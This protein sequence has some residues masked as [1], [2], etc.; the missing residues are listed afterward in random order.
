M[1]QKN[2]RKKRTPQDRVISSAG[3]NSPGGYMKLLAA[4]AAAAA[5]AAEDPELPLLDPALSRLYDPRRS[6]TKH[7]VKTRQQIALKGIM[8]VYLT[9]TYDCNCCACDHKADADDEQQV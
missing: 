2:A 1:A 3:D 8:F 6:C 9:E 7:I 4:A 5:A